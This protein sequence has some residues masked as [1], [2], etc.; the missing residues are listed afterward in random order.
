MQADIKHLKL[1][2]KFLVIK[3]WQSEYI[4]RLLASQTYEI[5]LQTAHLRY[6]QTFLEN[7]LTCDKYIMVRT[8]Y[9]KHKKDMTP[10]FEKL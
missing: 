5:R 7:L 4:S 6:Q 10:V 9:I 2:S 8:N 1:Y 3:Y